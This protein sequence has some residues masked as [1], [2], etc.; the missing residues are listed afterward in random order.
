[1]QVI[2]PD[3]AILLMYLQS[4]LVLSDTAFMSGSAS[5]KCPSLGKSNTTGVKFGFSSYHLTLTVDTP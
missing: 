2:I 4:K 3:T 1:M 5:K